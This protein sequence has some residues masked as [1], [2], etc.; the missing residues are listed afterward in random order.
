MIHI[1]LNYQQRSLTT[2][3]RLWTRPL[4]IWLAYTWCISIQGV[5]KVTAVGG[6]GTKRCSID[7][8]L[9]I[10]R[11]TQ[12]STVAAYER[13]AYGMTVHQDLTAAWW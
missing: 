4:P 8:D 11:C 1:L 9:T 13:M 12:I 3:R 5:T 6:H 10:G 2:A 7:A